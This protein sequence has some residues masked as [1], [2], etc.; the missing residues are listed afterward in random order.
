MKRPS[1][2]MVLGVRGLPEVQGG[3]ETHAEQL[4]RRLVGP[5]WRISILVR[6][7]CVAAT[8]TEFA[9]LRLIRLW[10][11]RRAGLEAFVHSLLGVAYAAVTR[12][13]ILHVHAIGPA[14]VAPLARLFGLR[15]V[16]THHGADYERAK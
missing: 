6:S 16:V 7:P 13:D 1:K 10:A 14:I 15:V 2:V 4:Y 9:G 12:P 8:R 11:P 5:S 3:V